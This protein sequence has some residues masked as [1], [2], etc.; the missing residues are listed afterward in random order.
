[1]ADGGDTSGLLSFINMAQVENER[2]KWAAFF[3]AN[4]LISC[5]HEE[6]ITQ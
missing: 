3:F 4:A 2:E 1:M 6:S 5:S